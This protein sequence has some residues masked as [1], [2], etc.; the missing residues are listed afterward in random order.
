MELIVRERRLG[1]FGHAL[2]ID[3][4][5]LLRQALQWELDTAK[6]KTGQSGKNWNDTMCQ[7]LRVIGMT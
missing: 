7:D 5:R 6:W 1:W 2:K 4:D 3:E